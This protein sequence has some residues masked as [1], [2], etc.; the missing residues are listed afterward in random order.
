[1]PAEIQKLTRDVLSKPVRIQIDHSKSLPNIEH[2]L[3]S[4]QQAGKTTLLKTLLQEKDMTRTLVFTRTKHKAKSLAIALQKAGIKAASMQG[5]LSQQKRQAAL[6]GFQQGT[7]PILVATDIAARGI[8]VQ[9]ISHVINYDLPDTMETYTHRTGRTGRA[10]NFGK[11]FSFV[12]QDD[13]R[14]IADLKRKFDFIMKAIQ[15]TDAVEREERKNHPPQRKA[16]PPQKAT[17]SAARRQGAKKKSKAVSF[18]FGLRPQA[19][20]RA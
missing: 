2:T 10:K 4:V 9:E 11:A 7:F 14:F 8:D 18:D 20:N 1:M 12:G 15:P 13:R 5:N 6:E 3:F 19:A 17:R 16:L